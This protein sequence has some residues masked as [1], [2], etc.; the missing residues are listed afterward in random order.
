MI[1]K[2]NIIICYRGEIMSEKFIVTSKT[3]KYKEDPYNIIT[4]RIPKEIRQEFDK[5]AGESD[6]S[7]NKLMCM[8]LQY[9]LDNLQFIPKDKDNE[10]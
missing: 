6:Y 7:R 3:V 1:L 2:C 4:L 9:A 8:A 10:Q 5:L